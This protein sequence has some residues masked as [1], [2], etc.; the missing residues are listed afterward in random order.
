MHIDVQIDF[1][2]ECVGQGVC[3]HLGIQL[4]HWSWLCSYITLDCDFSVC[5]PE[6]AQ[7]YSL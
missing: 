1:L 6:V 5:C 4:V 7:T 2:Q 3:V